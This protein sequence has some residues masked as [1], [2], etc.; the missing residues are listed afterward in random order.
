MKNFKTIVLVVFVILVFTTTAKAQ[1][2]VGVN[3]GVAMP[4]GSFGQV[5]NMGF[6]GYATAAYS[7]NSK[8]SLGFNLGFYAFKGTDYPAGSKPSARIIP[9]FA[10]FKYFLNTEGFMPYVGTGMGVYM[11]YSSVTTPAS[12]AVTVGGVIKEPAKLSI[13]H[14]TNSKK[15]GVSPTVGFWL[16]DDFKYGASVTYHIIFSDYSYIGINVGIIYLLGQ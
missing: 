15:F 6:G 5:E 7:V 8:I 11:T 1:I 3:A 16:G 2:N 9:I 12:D 14:L 10:D 13:E 4:M